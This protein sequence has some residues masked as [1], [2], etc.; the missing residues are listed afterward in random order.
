[1]RRTKHPHQ[2]IIVLSISLILIIANVNTQLQGNLLSIDEIIQE[3]PSTQINYVKEQLYVDP[4]IWDTLGF[5]GDSNGSIAIIGTGI[6]STHSKFGLDSYRDKDFTKKIIGWKDFVNISNPYPIDPN[7][8]STFTAASA[9]GNNNSNSEVP[10][11]SEN[12]TTIT[13]GSCYTQMK[14]FPTNPGPGW[15]NI[16]LGSFY[17]DQDNTNIT[18]NGTYIEYTANFIQSASFQIK[19]ENVVLNETIEEIHGIYRR[20]TYTT[21]SQAAIYDIYFH[22]YL[23]FSKPAN[24]CINMM[25]NFPLENDP[26]YSGIAP[27]TK[28]VGLRTLN[29]ELKGNVSSLIA[30]LNWTRNN[31][32]EYH[33]VGIQIDLGHYIWDASAAELSEIYEAVIESGIMVFIPSGDESV[34][35]DA[36][37]PLVTNEIPLVVGSVNDI[38]KI[39]YYTSLGQQISTNHKKI[40][41]LAPGGSYLAGHR[42]IFAADTND[43][44]AIGYVTDQFINDSTSL[45]GSSISTAFVAASY[46]LLI[47]ALGGYSIWETIRTPYLTL[48]LKSRLLMTATELNQVREDNPETT[49]IDESSIIFSPILN[50]GVKDTREGFGLLNIAAALESILFE[51]SVD[52]EISNSLV[53]ILGNSTGVH[54]FARKIQLTQNEY[55]NFTLEFS[56]TADLDFYIYKNTSDSYGDPIIIQKSTG[57]NR[58]ES[59]VFG[60]K[61][62][63]GLY[64]VIIKAVSGEFTNFTLNVTHMANVHI[65]ILTNHIANGIQGFNDILDTIEFVINYTDLDNLPPITLDLNITG[66]SE[67]ISFSK[68]SSDLNYADGCLYSTQFHFYEI[69]VYEYH[70][71]AWDGINLV[72]SPEIAN[73]TVEIISV[74]NAV[75]D[76]YTWD[77]HA[78][79]K[80]AFD[81]SWHN[82]SQ[83]DSIDSRGNGTMYWNGLYFGD[84]SSVLFG[85]YSYQNVAEL[86][87]STAYSPQIWLDETSN[88]LLQLGI[89]ISM[90][91]GDYFLINA[92]SNRTG[93]WVTLDSFTNVEEEWSLLKYNLSEFIS[94]YVQIQFV[95]ILDI[96][97][98][99]ELNK[100][101][102]IGNFNIL[103]QPPGNYY[104]SV[105]FNTSVFPERGPI[106]QNYRFS[107][108]IGDQDGIPPDIVY[109][110]IDHKN[111]TM[112]NI[113]GDFDSTYSEFN[114]NLQS[115]GITY[116]YDIYLATVSDS[117]FRI[118]VKTNG[119]FISTDFLSG[120]AT[121]SQT[122]YSFPFYGIQTHMSA[123][124][125]PQPHPQTIWVS[126]SNSFHFIT[127]DDVWYS[128]V[129][130]YLGYGT[131]W[132]VYLVTSLINIPQSNEETD[133]V[134]LW[135]EHQLLFDTPNPQLF[136][137]DF[138]SIKISSDFGTH[139]YDLET[140]DE[141]VAGYQ[142]QKI[143]LWNYKGMNVLIRF[144]FHSDDTSFFP[145]FQ[146]GWYLR[147][148]MV[149]VDELLDKEPP[150]ILFTNIIP[151]MEISGTFTLQIT[152][153]DPSGIDDARVTL[154]I[155]TIS[156]DDATA[157][158][159]IIIYEIDTTKYRNGNT[160]IAVLAYDEIGNKEITS[161]YVLIRNEGSP[162]LW[163]YIIV[164][165]SITLIVGILLLYF[166]V[167]KPFKRKKE[168]TQEVLSE[169]DK[170]K[171]LE[172]QRERELEEMRIREEAELA[173]PESE[174][175]KPFTYKCK[176]CSKQF[177]NKEYIWSMIC[178]DCNT[179]TLNL[180]YE[181][182]LCGKL[183][184]Y[185]I[186][187]DYFCKDCNIKLLK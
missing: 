30:A 11:D 14:L 90:N 66:F 185:D 146:T 109:L 105:I 36:L 45:V 93:T 69:G 107:T 114:G 55:Y 6:D 89:R 149:N 21:S 170:Q 63:S 147:D 28:I 3:P 153:L 39:T 132:D 179:D 18:L 152:I 175:L 161:T 180:V 32:D 134:Y 174:A 171:I 40:D 148:I 143:D 72:R 135:F 75:Y 182:K 129:N 172:E 168:L 100:G 51:L 48:A 103:Q 4:Y 54:S 82:I 181:C 186:Q 17:M 95:V 126:S 79:N 154:F 23:D 102:L 42:T 125:S 111:Y 9:Y 151:N 92:R 41:I 113:Y 73:Y 158:N 15:F 142:T 7:G 166:Q 53:S 43:N 80:W 119:D 127:Q 94:S 165:I 70:I 122:N 128:G 25:L 96:I 12:R 78:M 139:W 10:L 91:Q 46:N 156:I 57:E 162:F 184:Y 24:F 169:E 110:E 77:F 31:R 131:N 108:I 38:G 26:D 47:E 34:A 64:I 50:R 5:T 144:E 121:S 87:I 98:D 115:G 83:F 56:N 2:F 136:G 164:G 150:T 16:K 116:A 138:A 97:Q 27:A 187:G 59:I 81:G 35:S 106:Y 65:P 22:Y 133:R 71:I 137:D 124:G 33:I 61:Q 163:V 68:K 130:Y 29:E 112:F 167:I 104:P 13:L 1:M 20:L 178:P 86:S 157:E 67:V 101:I 155:N 60:L 123:Y 145:G 52:T 49:A 118:H 99:I 88:P 159:G 85:E 160:T 183:Y 141:N 74:Q 176:R 117:N 140:Y 76:N 37:N 8:L 19:Q 177:Q 84:N 58:K 173:T 120:P 44:D 62:D